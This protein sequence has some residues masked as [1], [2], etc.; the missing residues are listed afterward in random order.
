MSEKK[1]DQSLV[2]RVT[3]IRSDVQTQVGSQVLSLL[4]TQDSTLWAEAPKFRRILSGK[5][6]PNDASYVERMEK[7]AKKLLKAKK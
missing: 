1:Y 3:K 5:A 7:A 6:Y 4:R 2:S